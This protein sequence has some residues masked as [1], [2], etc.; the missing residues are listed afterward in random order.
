MFY[1]K[2][3]MRHKKM[4]KTQAL[5]LQVNK[6]DTKP[7]RFKQPRKI[8]SEHHSEEGSYSSTSSK[9]QHVCAFKA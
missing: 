1:A 2:L 8:T 7:Q 4:N 3:S 6:T 5:G 9:P